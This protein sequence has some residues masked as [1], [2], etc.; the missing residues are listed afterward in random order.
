MNLRSWASKSLFVIGLAA[1]GNSAQ[2][3]HGPLA[4]TGHSHPSEAGGGVYE[5][6]RRSHPELAKNWDGFLRTG[7]IE[8]LRPALDPLP[9]GSIL[10]NEGDRALVWLSA[11]AA[12]SLEEAGVRLS[13]PRPRPSVAPR[14]GSRQSHETLRSM[15]PLQSLANAVSAD[16]MME[17]LDA[18]AVEIQT[19]YYNTAGMQAAT[20]YALDRFQEYGL[21]DA[22]FDAF[23]YNGY[24]VRNVI[25]VKIGTV[26]PSRIYMICGHL[27]STS[28]QNQTLAPGAEDNGSGAVGV[29]EAARLLAPLRTESTI[30]FVCF[31]AEEQGLIG[32][33]HLASLADQQNWDLRG[34]LNMDMVGYDRSGAPDLWIEGF[35]SNPASVALMDLL[36]DVALAYTDMGVYRYPSDG[37]GSDH[38]PF[39]DHGF[40]AILAIDYDWDNYSCYH[41]TCDVVGNIVPSHLRRMV[42][43]VTVAGAQ[44]AGIQSALGSV[45]GTADRIDSGDDAGIRIEVLGTQY[46]P[47]FSGA[48]GGFTLPD[49]LPGTY[50]LRATAAGYDDQDAQVTVTEGASTP[51]TI[52]LDPIEPAAISGIVS[53]QGGGNPSG[54]RIFAEDQAPVAI[55]GVSG[56][57]DLEPV[58]PGT[59]VV[60]AN[61]PSRMPAARTVQIPSGESLTGVDFVLKTVWDFEAAS[62]DLAANTGWQWGTDAT[63]GAHSGTKV[64]GTKLGANYDNCADY[65]LDLPPLDLRFY[66]SARLHFWHWYKTEGTYDGGNV[67]VSTDGGSTWVVL[68]PVGGY[69]DQLRGSCNPLANQGGYAG[70]GTTWREGIVDL[71]SYTGRSIRVR[72]W[73]GSDSGVR[74]RG[75][76]IDDISLEGTLQPSSVAA[77]EAPRDALLSSLMIRPNPI[78]SISS[79]SFR[80]GAPG[81]TWVTVFDA[82]G[83]KVRSLRDGAALE[84]GTQVV[85]WDGRDDAG[86][87]APAGVYWLRV[88]VNGRT[89][90]QPLTIVR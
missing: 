83:R 46:A 20:Q 67:Q 68:P 40:P 24:S 13:E 4:L 2:G 28:P 33:Q 37:Y 34:V 11:E 15:T 30:Y 36:E 63:A 77:G 71:A 62:E 14:F 66:Q 38:V 6:D 23:V 65:R 75:W 70:T 58:Q 56:A 64:W 87:P 54:A 82:A 17:G 53:L 90:T 57:Y 39:D 48:G 73:F 29:L 49:L 89:E 86:R 12:R 31:T 27:D 80:L 42:L 3:R 7:A 61:F 72:F 60:S 22:Y 88:F 35:P 1:M 19:R 81:E 44:L 16:R 85:A 79:V 25:G 10:H 47:V 43:T 21:D 41:Q 74:D 55:A 45:D 9:A 84:A 18:I 51:V 26:H 76:Y 78:R 50:T 52:P 59:V 32:S 69:P 8:S 5:I